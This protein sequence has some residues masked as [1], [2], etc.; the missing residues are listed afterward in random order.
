MGSDSTPQMISGV[1]RVAPTLT[2]ARGHLPAHAEGR[3]SVWAAVPQGGPA[4]R[5]EGG[6]TQTL[7]TE[8]SQ[9]WCSRHTCFRSDEHKVKNS[10]STW[11]GTLGM[12]LEPQDTVVSRGL[13]GT[14]LSCRGSQDS[15]DAGGG[16]WG[17]CG[18]Q[19]LYHGQGGP[20]PLAAALIL[21]LSAHATIPH[22]PK[23]PRTGTPHGG[24]EKPCTVPRRSAGA[25]SSL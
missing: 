5:E 6:R 24:Q 8:A 2:S 7:C 9:G 19:G 23:Y 21:L 4:Q 15:V 22:T 10:V 20:H 17:V 16:A 13:P 11:H 1:A 12:V 14:A 3:R 25:A 18:A